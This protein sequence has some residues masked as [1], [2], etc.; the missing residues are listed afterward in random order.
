MKC[1]SCED[2]K[3]YD[4]IDCP[5]HKDNLCDCDCHDSSTKPHKKLEKH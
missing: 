5:D 3:H 4:C 1:A 2:H